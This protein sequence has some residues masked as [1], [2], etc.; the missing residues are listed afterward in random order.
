ML[1]RF[2]A[3][4]HAQGFLPDAVVDL[5]SWAAGERGGVEVPVLRV[6]GQRARRGLPRPALAPDP[7]V[8]RAEPGDADG[9]PNL[10]RLLAAAREAVGAVARP[11]LA[12]PRALADGPTLASLPE[13]G[14]EAFLVDGIDQA[15]TDPLDLLRP[16]FDAGYVA[17]HGGA[18]ITDRRA[19]LRSGLV[20][21]VGRI[22]AGTR[23]TVAMSTLGANGRFANQL[24]QYLYLTF[25]GLRHGLERAVPDWV[26]AG[27]YGLANPP[28]DGLRLPEL[29]FDAFDNDDLALWRLRDPPREVD[30]WGYFQ[31]MPVCWAPHRA[32]AR[33]L[34]TLRDD[35]AAPLDR[36]LA[37]VT[38]GGRRPLV[39]V[40]VR[41]G[42]YVTI[43]RDGLPW[44][45]PVPEAWYAAWL[46][47]TMAGLADPVLFVGTD[48]PATVLPHFARFHP[49]VSDDV[50]VPDLPPD[51]AD[52]EVMRRADA[53]AIANS[54]FSRMAAILAPDGQACAAPDVST[55]SFAPYR[56][57]IDPDFW[58]RFEAGAKA[59]ETFGYDEAA[60]EA[61]AINV[62]VRTGLARRQVDGLEGYL[63]QRDRGA[64]GERGGERR[65]ER[66]GRGTQGLPRPARPRRS[67]RTRRRAPR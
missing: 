49:L 30:L 36:R 17:L 5:T 23:G 39:A 3:A 50:A 34:F 44:Y 11:V 57:W 67:G 38:D 66:P 51:I 48:D 8:L 42:D 65:A 58:G 47:E 59:Y 29:R 54:S 24:F 16:A 21:D 4:L 20:R 12:L 63:A 25:Y 7:V 52:F 13:L 53:L 62:R 9:R 15:G 45:R 18:R 35:L 60:R 43:H 2:L 22:G 28:A 64:P 41:R 56:P 27:L 40:H 1:T 61:R 31:E 10:A 6:T 46:D 26:G 14:V 19:F 55:R 33:A 37:E 32:L